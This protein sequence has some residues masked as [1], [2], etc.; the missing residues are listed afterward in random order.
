LTFAQ[1]VEHIRVDDCGRS[2]LPTDD[3]DR[4]KFAT[5]RL[6]PNDANGRSED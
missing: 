4:D 6:H 3:R 1:A 5:E 2:R